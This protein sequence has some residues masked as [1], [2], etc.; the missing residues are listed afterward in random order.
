M[1]YLLKSIGSFAYTFPGH[2]KQ[3]IDTPKTQTSPTARINII[4]PKT[5]TPWNSQKSTS[6]SV[7]S[8]LHLLWRDWLNLSQRFRTSAHHVPSLPIA[9]VR[10]PTN[11]TRRGTAS[12]HPMQAWPTGKQVSQAVNVGC[13]GHLWDLIIALAQLKVIAAWVSF[14]NARV[15]CLW[16]AFS[17]LGT[18]FLLETV[19]KND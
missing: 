14:R 18:V 16:L 4:K 19:R 2:S 5:F 1:D 13:T 9:G 6:R 3:Q 12:A 10:R 7:S 15:R 8:V 11:G 17:S